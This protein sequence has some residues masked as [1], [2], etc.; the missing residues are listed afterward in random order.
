MFCKIP[1]AVSSN[2]FDI[3]F[4]IYLIRLRNHIVERLGKLASCVHS[5]IATVVVLVL[6]Q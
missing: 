4:M 1:R 2:D 3:L 5:T 6:K